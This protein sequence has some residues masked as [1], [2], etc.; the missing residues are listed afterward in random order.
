MNTLKQLSKADLAFAVRKQKELIDLYQ[1]SL[2]NKNQ[3]ILYLTRLVLLNKTDTEY[4]G[5]FID[6]KV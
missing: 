5:T 1:S 3:A 6:E 4:P 2:D